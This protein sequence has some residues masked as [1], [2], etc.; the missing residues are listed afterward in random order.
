MRS[1]G[2]GPWPQGRGGRD[3]YVDVPGSHPMSGRPGED[4]LE[5]A[6][7]R[8]CLGC[9]PEQD[10]GAISEVECDRAGAVDEDSDDERMEAGGEASRHPKLRGRGQA[11]ANGWALRDPD[12]GQALGRSCQ[13]QD[14][15]VPGYQHGRPAG[16]DRHGSTF[17]HGDDE[18]RGQGPRHPGALHP[19]IPLEPPFDLSRRHPQHVGLGGQPCL[20]GDF[21]G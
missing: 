20:L 9:V 19:G 17:R 18:R 15:S 2:V 5:G 11:E 8:A 13:P 3:A 1:L 21:A 12:S 4:A 10:P 16:Q 14:R 7:L 6:A